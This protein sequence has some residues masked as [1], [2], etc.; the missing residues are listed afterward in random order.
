MS[1]VIRPATGGIAM[2]DDAID[3][4]QDAQYLAYVLRTW[5]THLDGYLLDPEW[6]I[7]DQ[8]SHDAVR[9]QLAQMGRLL[10]RITELV[11]RPTVDAREHALNA[12]SVREAEAIL[13]EYGRSRLRAVS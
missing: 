9:S 2:S 8:G 11:D 12:R 1:I 6:P 4:A 13:A 3:Q 10:A 7:R 5:A